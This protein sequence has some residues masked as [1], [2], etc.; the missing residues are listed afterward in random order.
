MNA[1]DELIG[2][3]DEGADSDEIHARK[4]KKKEK[5]E[6]KKMKTKQLKRKRRM[7]K[8]KKKK[9]RRLFQSIQKMSHIVP[10]SFYINF[11]F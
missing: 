8:M 11:I 3:F 7:I 5:K 2:A 1:A 4:G 10:V 9:K 6:D